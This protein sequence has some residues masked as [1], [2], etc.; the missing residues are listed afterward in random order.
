[1]KT[2]TYDKHGNILEAGLQAWFT[3]ND[4]HEYWNIATIDPTC[5]LARIKLSTS[6]RT[7]K[8]T[9]EL[10]VFTQTE[11]EVEL[12]LGHD[13][14]FTMPEPFLEYAGPRTAVRR[15]MKSISGQYIYLLA[16][17]DLESMCRKAGIA[18]IRILDAYDWDADNTDERTCRNLAYLLKERS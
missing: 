2:G 4:D 13:M 12:L 16:R 9:G 6:R 1:M 14:P 11:I 3:G 17:M 7:S 15:I 8:L 5:T 18:E 10:R